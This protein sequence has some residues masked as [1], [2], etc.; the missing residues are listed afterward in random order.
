[1]SADHAMRTFAQ[2]PISAGVTL[3]SFSARTTNDKWEVQF[4][5]PE[6][7]RVAHKVLSLENC[8]LYCML[9]CAVLPGPGWDTKPGAARIP[10]IG[11]ARLS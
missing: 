2:H 3:E 11:K 1:M 9:V 10:Q 5:S 4:V 6:T 8:G 7:N